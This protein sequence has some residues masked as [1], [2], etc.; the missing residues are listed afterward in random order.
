[1]AVISGKCRTCDFAG[2]GGQAMRLELKAFNSRLCRRIFA[3]F[4][5]CAMV[6]VI[7]LAALS[8]VQV[9]SQLETQANQRLRRAAKSH[10]LSIYEHLLFCEDELKLVG[11]RSG[12]DIGQQQEKFSAIGRHFPDGRYEALLGDP[13]DDISLTPRE[14]AH[15]TSGQSVLVVIGGDTTDIILIRHFDAGNGAP[16]LLMATLRGEYLWGLEKGNNLP[17]VSEFAVMTANG[18]PLYQSG[19]WPSNPS[20]MAGLLSGKRLRLGIAATDWFLAHWSVF[21]KPQFGIESWSVVVLQ[22]ENDVLAPISQFK[23][24]FV[25]VVV[26]ALLLVVVLSIFNLR[27]SLEPIE[28]LKIGARQIAEKNFGHRV[29]VSSRDEFQEL[30]ESF[31]TMSADLGKQF[32]FLATRAEIDRSTIAGKD[33]K[34]I[35]GLAIDRLL[36]NFRFRRVS[37]A[38]VSPEEPDEAVIYTGDRTVPDI[39]FSQPFDVADHHLRQLDR[40]RSWIILEDPEAVSRYLPDDFIAQAETAVLFPVYIRERLFA[41]IYVA[42]RPEAHSSENTFSPVRQIA[43]HLAVAWSNLKMIQDL[44]QLTLGSM[45]ALARAVDAKSPWTAGHSARVMRVALSIGRHMA[46]PPASM[47]RLEQAALLHDIG[48]IGISSKI[49]DKP[50]QLTAE[51]FDT[52]K[53]HPVIGDRILAP[54]PVF[55]K[56]IP[57]VRQHHERWDGKGYPDGLSGE[58]ITLEARILAVSDVY[59]AMT[60]DRPYREG[61]DPER[62]IAII[63]SEAGSQLDPMVVKAFLELMQQKSAMAA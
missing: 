33:F 43:D 42:S 51:E 63:G 20:D 36:S 37:I 55:K 8:L 13:I 27:R 38:R 53:S 4:I 16:G 41:L 10:G 46:L 28:A 21:L 14:Q 39:I 26:L 30:A 6:P 29:K 15:L 9:S 47:D 57:L 24:I 22:P 35:A 23:A 49:L 5:V 52:I 7:I 58:A 59:D 34:S 19:G 2:H 32:Q 40:D 50:G 54:I 11:L 45:Q 17:P 3:T 31:N 25:L 1:M 61:M 48:K 62:A 44:R 56:I 60:S 18:L 12:A